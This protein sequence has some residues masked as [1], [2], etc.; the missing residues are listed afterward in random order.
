MSH[1]VVSSEA[2]NLILVNASDA[3]VGSLDKGACHDGEGVLH[4]AFSIFLFDADNRLLIQQRSPGK[5]LWPLYWANSCCSHPRVGETLAEATERR[6]AE[7]LGVTSALSFA[8]RFEYQALYKD[9]GAEHELCSVF[10]GRIHPADLDINDTEIAAVRWLRM[11]E[12]DQLM[13]AP[14]DEAPLVAPWFKLEWQRFRGDD[15]AFLHQFLKS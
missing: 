8:Y 3:V 11:E 2:E 6:M 12:V 15:A 7:E 14:V 10:V 1:E 13:Q 9:L 4:R 5:R